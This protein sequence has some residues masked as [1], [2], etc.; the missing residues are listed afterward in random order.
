MR[1][2]KKDNGIDGISTIF[3]GEKSVTD[4]LTRTCETYTGEILVFFFWVL[5]NNGN[6]YEEIIQ[7]ESSL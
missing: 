6:L 2:E 5:S 4:C 1:K 3:F 7:L